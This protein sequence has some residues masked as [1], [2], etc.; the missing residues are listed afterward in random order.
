MKEHSTTTS[1]GTTG[2]FT[3]EAWFDPIEAGIRDR[4]RGFIQELLEQELT[5]ALG[6]RSK[7]E[8]AA[9]PPKDY[10]NGTRERD[11][12]GV[13][14][15]GEPGWLDICGELIGHTNAPSSASAVT[16]R[17]PWMTRTITTASGKGV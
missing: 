5:A 11:D 16:S 6:G 2:L 17:A 1:D 9:E 13:D 7:H 4:V 8:R 15:I 10:R 14:R 3:G 12:M